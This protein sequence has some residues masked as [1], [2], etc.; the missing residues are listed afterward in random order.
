MVVS[1]TCG[2]LSTALPRTSEQYSRFWWVGGPLVLLYLALGG[3]FAKPQPGPDAMAGFAYIPLIPLM[4]AWILLGIVCT[5]RFP[6]NAAGFLRNFYWALSILI[7]GTG[8][9]TL[10][11]ELVSPYWTQTT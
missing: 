5:V 8:A 7:I 10:I 3:I 6:L 9:L 11:V 4:A 2:I 1:G